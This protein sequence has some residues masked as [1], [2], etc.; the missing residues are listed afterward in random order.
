MPGEKH[1]LDTDASS[2]VSTPAKKLKRAETRPC[3]I[4][5]EII[6]LRLLHKHAELESERLEEIIR[7]VGSTEPI[8][9][10]EFE[11]GSSKTPS[12]RRSSARARKS[13]QT[14][15]TDT[16]AQAAKTLQ[17]IKRNRR[18][19]YAKLRELTKE[20]DEGYNAPG[21]RPFGGH[22]IICPVCSQTV[23][24]DEDVVDA[25][26]DACIADEAR[27]QEEER[28]RELLR[29]Q[30]DMEDDLDVVGIDI[31]GTGFH[32]RREE[33]DVDEE[34]D[35]DGDDEFG[36]VQFTEG[37]ILAPL[38]P[39]EEIDLDGEGDQTLRDLVAEGKAVKR[40]SPP[41]D[42]LEVVKAKMDEVMGIGECDKLDRAIQTAKK[43]QDPKALVAAL[44][45][46]LKQLESLRV[47]SSTSLLCRIC[48]D[49]YTEPTVSTGCWHTCCRE[50]WL[51]CL[52]STKLCPICKRITAATDL[53]R[54]YL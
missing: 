42:G 15:A 54:V 20:E 31:R 50:C 2:S 41:Q 43:M 5:D 30:E 46:K 3:P 7:S 21:S 14:V 8:L 40:Q 49:P 28:Q 16:L 6:P 1:G 39:D 37:D 35:V 25:H 34:I 51:R 33:P 4:C 10:P 22:E 47:S 53:R 45:N 48:L 11:E 36:D 17:T 18:Q 12:R 44:E 29:I 19:R 24:G 23:R 13:F 27:K 32:T 9:R 38:R 52:G 26:V